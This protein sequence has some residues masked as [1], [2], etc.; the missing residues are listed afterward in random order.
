VRWSRL[1]LSTFMRGWSVIG[2]APSGSWCGTA[3]TGSAA[4]AGGAPADDADELLAQ[5]VIRRAR[6]GEGDAGGRRLA[7]RSGDGVLAV[8]EPGQR[9][10]HPGEADTGGRG[11]DPLG[12]VVGIGGGDLGLPLE[13]LRSDLVEE[14]EHVLGTHHDRGPLLPQRHQVQGLIHEREAHEAHVDLSRLE[15]LVL[16]R[17]RD[18]D[19]LE[20]CPAA[21]RLPAPQEAI[22]LDPGDEADAQGGGVHAPSLRPARPPVPVPRGPRPR[23]RRRGDGSL[24]PCGACRRDPLSYL[25]TTTAPAARAVAATRSMRMPPPRRR[26]AAPIPRTPRLPRTTIRTPRTRRPTTPRRRTTAPRR[27]RISTGPR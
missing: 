27:H 7:Q 1:K 20:P 3:G 6:P 21:P 11:G 5:R 14:A 4:G 24:T 19:Q 9:Q 17:E 26:S 15:H 23:P 12:G 22:G 2:D 18:G 16:P 25:R 13:V 8:V 10:R